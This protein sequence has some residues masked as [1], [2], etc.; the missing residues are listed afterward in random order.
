MVPLVCKYQFG[1]FELSTRAHE[2]R[3]QGRKLK[4]R[5]QAYQIL[6]LLLE[7]AGEV[8]TREQV[9]DRVWASDTF[10]D[11]EHGLNTAVK[12]LRGVLA[13]SAQEPRYI[14]TLPKLGYRLI[15]AV[16]RIAGPASAESAA[17][18][19]SIPASQGSGQELSSPLPPRTWPRK[20][21]ALAAIAV[22]AGAAIVF[23][24]G[25]VR[26]RTAKGGEKAAEAKTRSTRLM[27][28]VLPFENLTGDAAQDYFSDG[29]TE[30]MIAQLGRLDPEHV[31]VIAR[32]SVMHY[33]HTQEPLDQ[34]G[35]ELGVQYVL[36]GSVRRDS[37]RVRVTAQ[38]VQVRDQASVWTREYDRDLI[39]LLDLQAEIA[40]EIAKEM[41]VTLGS[42]LKAPATAT[43]VKPDRAAGVYEAYDLY[44]KGRYYWN[45]R[46][47]DGFGRAA[48]YFQKA[49]AKDPQFP[50]AYAG[51][52]NTYGLMS[53]WG[54]AAP[55]EVMP[56]ARAAALRAL[57]LDDS[58]AE[59]HVSLALIAENFDYDWTKAE[60]EFRR[61]IELNPEYA[62][63]HQWFAEYLSWQG[64]FDEALAESEQARQLD[65]LS[66]IIATDHGAILCFARQYDRAIEHLRAVVEMDPGFARARQIMALSYTHQGK[67]A[68]AFAVLEGQPKQED[69]LSAWPWAWKAYVYG[70]WGREPEA[71]TALAKVEETARLSGSD[72]ALPL[73]IAYLGMGRADQSMALLEKAYQER[74][75]AVVGMKVAPWF[76]FLRSDP[77]FQELLNRAGL[78]K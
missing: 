2:L 8:V 9:R 47:A 76:D 44:L 50:R 42:G 67:F 60:N 30:E 24:Y 3:K 62:T 20:S 1:P 73:L 52:A 6:L 10:V 41:G 64:R 58:L 78:A 35:R 32:T 29:L 48:D 49:I 74:S 59:A 77:R 17:T 5:P 26:S 28:A 61:A 46:T 14:E 31:G 4:L 55:R 18:G 36:E 65:P 72:P 34:I 7:H 27:L 68:E 22:V 23:S 16:E 75:N 40:R 63:A 21:W 54:V 71:R 13:D 38:L 70:R 25:W 66:L 15:A 37:G 12:E 69:E 53:T 11:F 51:L 19:A 56:K 57:E 39:G 33:K 43:A 45:K